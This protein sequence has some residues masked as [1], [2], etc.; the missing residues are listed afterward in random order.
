MSPV[1]VLIADDHRSFAEAIALRLAAEAD[2]VVVGTVGTVEAAE[3][4]A[5]SLRPDVLLL[6]VELGR[7][8][9]IGLARRLRDTLQATKVVIVTFRDD[10]DTASA[11]VR[12]GVSGFMAKDATPD[13]LVQA[14]RNVARG[15]RWIQPRLLGPVL[16]ELSR[17]P[18]SLTQDQH[19]LA[20]LSDRER[21]VLHCLVRGMDRASIARELFLSTNT[22]RTHTRNLLAKLDVHS[23]LEAVAVALRAGMRPVDDSIITR[24]VS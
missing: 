16:D 21:V 5:T 9:G 17:H 8:D 7:G 2:F 19:K 24:A 4:A 20:K 12:A 11:A 18:G 3:E 15:E 14:V 23:S 1:R 13:E 22:V 6:D 10:I